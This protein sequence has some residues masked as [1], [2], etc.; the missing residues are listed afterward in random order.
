MSLYEFKKD[1]L[2]VNVIKAYPSQE[3]F[4]YSG[5]VYYQNQNKISG[6]YVNNVYGIPTG[7]INLFVENVDRQQL[8]TGR[9]IGISSSVSEQNVRDTG[10]IYPYLVKNSTGVSFKTTTLDNYQNT[11]YG[12]IMTSSYRLSSS[13]ARSIHYTFEEYGIRVQNES[14]LN[15]STYGP[16]SPN[17]LPP[18]ELKTYFTASKIGAMRTLF[19]HYSKFAKVFDFNSSSL[20]YQGKTDK[21]TENINLIEIPSL[22]YGSGIKKGTVEL[23]YYITGTLVA[24]AKDTKQNGEL[25]QTYALHTTASDLVVGGVMYNHGFIFLVNSSSF[26]TAYTFSGSSVNPS[27]LYFGMGANDGIN[28]SYDLSGSSRLIFSGTHRIPNITMFANAPK[29]ELNWSNNPTYLS[30]T[31]TGSVL[32]TGSYYFTEKQRYIHNTISSSIDNYSASF[33]KATYINRVN[34]Y[35]EAGNLIGIAKT[36]KP[37]KKTEDTDFTFK[38]KLD[39]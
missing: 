33:A 39:M 21:T 36:S 14:V 26:T 30:F 37:I 11:D 35:D 19:D 28:A 38:L 5:S 24:T 12:T 16:S 9:V 17:P 31:A 1:D 22:F 7:Y 25:I 23:N 4:I 15:N 2:L 3:F 13:I 29:G 18:E 34:I 10:I 27:W 32:E 6:Q 20:T 8:N